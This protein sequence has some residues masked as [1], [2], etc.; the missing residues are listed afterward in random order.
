MPK[1]VPTPIIRLAVNHPAH[2]LEIQ[3]AQALARFEALRARTAEQFPDEV[4]A[5]AAAGAVMGGGD[6]RQITT[7]DAAATEFGLA[8]QIVDDIL[9]VEGAP[10]MLGKTTGKDAA[11]GKLTYP[12]L[13]GLAAARRMAADCLDRA[14]QSLRSGG[15]LDNRLMDIGEWIVGRVN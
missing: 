9:D 15:L 14:E 1:E 12:A 3:G 2:S 5:A 8:F 4:L 11:A 7:I 10:A 6:E 13:Y